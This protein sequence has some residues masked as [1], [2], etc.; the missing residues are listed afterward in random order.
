MNQLRQKYDTNNEPWIRMSPQ[1]AQT[2]KRHH[3]STSLT[4]LGTLPWFDPELPGQDADSGA[5]SE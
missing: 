4:G 3:S 5:L 1:V 2:C